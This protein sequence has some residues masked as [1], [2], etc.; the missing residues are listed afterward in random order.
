VVGDKEEHNNLR[1]T[2]SKSRPATVILTK[3]F[4][5][6]LSLSTQVTGS[7]LTN[8]EISGVVH[9]HFIIQGYPSLHCICERVIT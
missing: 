5:V 3:V 7:D 6:A 2:D 1:V 8:A 4:V 9:L